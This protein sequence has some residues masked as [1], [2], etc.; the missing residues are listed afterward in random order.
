MGQFR[1]RALMVAILILALGL[2]LAIQ[3]RRAARLDA[4]VRALQEL[5]ARITKLETD[6]LELTR[7][8][9]RSAIETE[10]LEPV[11]AQLRKALAETQ[12]VQSGAAR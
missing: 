1:M 8:Q 5:T 9:L 10:K 4:K 7:A 3:T 12:E 2:A 6:K 11:R